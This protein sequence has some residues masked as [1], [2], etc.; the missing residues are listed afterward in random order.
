MS[1]LLLEVYTCKLHAKEA[2]QH[3]R[4][5]FYSELLIV[6]SFLYQTYFSARSQHSSFS[7]LNASFI[8][9]TLKYDYISLFVFYCSDVNDY[10]CR[11]WFLW[12]CLSA[13]KKEEIWLFYGI[14]D[15]I[16]AVML[17]K[18]IVIVIEDTSI[19]ISKRKNVKRSC[20]AIFHEWWRKGFRV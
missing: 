5:H 6:S 12:S 14:N 9:N 20:R 10:L 2:K 4:S 11:F 3:I 19:E 7:Q 1:I 17:T 15:G 13:E 8:P 18:S 16:R